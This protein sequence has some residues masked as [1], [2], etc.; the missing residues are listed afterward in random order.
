[1]GS[2]VLLK[3]WPIAIIHRTGK[4]LRIKSGARRI[5]I[6]LSEEATEVTNRGCLLVTHLETCSYRICALFIPRLS[7]RVSKLWHPV[8]NTHLPADYPPRN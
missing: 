7:F 2:L 5:G 8:L 1:M 6:R 3:I 4:E